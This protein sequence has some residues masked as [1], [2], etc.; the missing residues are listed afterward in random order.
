MQDGS[1]EN[2]DTWILGR[3]FI[4]NYYTIF[5]LEEEKIG[6]IRAKKSD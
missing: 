1:D 4:N 5:D 2:K 3:N 6:M